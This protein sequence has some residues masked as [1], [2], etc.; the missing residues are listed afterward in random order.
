MT[1]L[2]YLVWVY[3][4]IGFWTLAV[5]PSSLVITVLTGSHRIGH[6]LHA[7][8]WGRLILRTCGVR[9]RAHGV[10]RL[11]PRQ[12]YVL[13]INHNSHFAGYAA[14]A[15]IPLQWRAVLA[16][17]LRKIP[18]F[19]WIGVLAGHIFI[20]THR[21]PRAIASLNAAVEKIHGGLSVLIFPEGAYHAQT[22]L[23]PFRAG[24]FHLAI[25][26]GVPIVPLT[27]VEHRRPGRAGAVRALDL[28]VDEPIPT[29]GCT[30]DDI[31]SLAE[32]TRNAM[33]TRI[34]RG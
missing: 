3:T 32:R 25:H 13:M 26:A 23:L 22:E 17:K 10:E 2:L 7:R 30:A 18:V 1:R 5:F 12:S 9:L 20:D 27:A 11:R 6:R 16:L 4:M 15:A 19:G 34:E 33:T 24:G 8:L 21:T 14:A 29:A 31:T 28:Y